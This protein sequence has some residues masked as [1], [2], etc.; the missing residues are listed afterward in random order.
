MIS[1]SL[2]AG[3]YETEMVGDFVL[4]SFLTNQSAILQ[5]AFGQGS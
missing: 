4:W 3:R 1:G 2:C 5:H